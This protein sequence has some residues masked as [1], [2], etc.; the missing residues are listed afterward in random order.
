MAS[1]DTIIFSQIGNSWKKIASD[2]DDD[3]SIGQLHE[4]GNVK[5]DWKCHL[6]CYNDYKSGINMF[7][8]I[9]PSK[10]R[11]KIVCAQCGEC[12]DMISF[13]FSGAAHKFL[14]NYIKENGV[15]HN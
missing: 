4:V 12:E 9:S 15:K 10:G 13:L 7:K 5:S 1:M 6:C 2:F 3:P 8:L 11:F 14:V